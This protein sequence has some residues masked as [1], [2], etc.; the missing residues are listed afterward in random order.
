MTGPSSG[1]SAPARFGIA[2][3]S[4]MTTTANMSTRQIM[5]VYLRTGANWDIRIE[6][7]RRVRDCK[8]KVQMLDRIVYV[9]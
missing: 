4:R 3:W 5:R 9:E 2:K 8:C 6:R 1:C 7:A